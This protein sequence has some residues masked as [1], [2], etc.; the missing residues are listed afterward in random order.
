VPRGACRGAGSRRTATGSWWSS[1]PIPCSAGTGS[2]RTANRRCGSGTSP[3]SG[4]RSGETRDAIFRKGRRSGPGR[5]AERI[6]V[7]KARGPLP[8]PRGAL[9][10][11]RKGTWYRRLPRE[12]LGRTGRGGGEGRGGRRDPRRPRR[13][14]VRIQG[15]AVP[16]G[17][18]PAEVSRGVASRE[19]VRLLS[20]RMICTK[21][22]ILFL[23]R[24]ES[25]S[26]V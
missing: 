16:D 25:C 6:F 22:Y 19:I 24:S 14:G 20:I 8:F 17:P 10:R 11:V 9:L 3:P 2:G 23:E 18:R 5:E 1:P 21:R 15:E 13:A 26:T 12:R 4:R 7:R